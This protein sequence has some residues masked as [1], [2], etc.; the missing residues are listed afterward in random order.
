M[1]REEEEGKDVRE[2]FWE[3]GRSTDEVISRRWGGEAGEKLYM[4]ISRNMRL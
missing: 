1:A 3:K 2:V 4:R